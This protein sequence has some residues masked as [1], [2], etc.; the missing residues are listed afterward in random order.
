MRKASTGA[1]GEEVHIKDGDPFDHDTRFMDLESDF[2][3]EDAMSF[4]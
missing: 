2:G 4:R 1:N 3:S